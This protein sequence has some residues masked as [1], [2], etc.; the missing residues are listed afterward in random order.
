MTLTWDKANN[1]SRIASKIIYKSAAGWLCD[2][3][4]N[5]MV[6]E[7]M[8]AIIECKTKGKDDDYYVKV[9][10]YSALHWMMFWR[11]GALRSKLRNSRTNQY[12]IPSWISY[13]D[14]EEWI[15]NS[16]EAFEFIEPP[17]DVAEIAKLILKA[18]KRNGE[19]KDLNVLRDAR[20]VQLRALGYNLDAIAIETGM[21]R[22]YVKGRCQQLRRFILRLL[23]EVENGN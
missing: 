7:G 23:E 14:H 19:K 5:D 4:F 6:S 12:Q 13:E 17:Y 8:I 15:A 21:S 20:I 3:D 22:S 2:D 18:K 10:K 9:A 11:Y 16:Q 1:L